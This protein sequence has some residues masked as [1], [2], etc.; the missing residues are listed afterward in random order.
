MDLGGDAAIGPGLAS[1]KF[2]ECW[3]Q[4]LLP[5]MEIRLTQT[6][7]PLQDDNSPSEESPNVRSAVRIRGLL[8][9]ESA[10]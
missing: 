3:K 2:E 4:A 1:K 9:S 10:S 5:C 7:V 6:E 8:R